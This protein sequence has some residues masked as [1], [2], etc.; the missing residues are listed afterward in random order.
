MS[1][2]PNNFNLRNT[3][4]GFAIAVAFLV[5]LVGDWF[6]ENQWTNPNWYVFELVVWSAG[7]GVFFFLF[8][9]DADPE[10]TREDSVSE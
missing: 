5:S 1:E 3:I 10:G 2:S 8:R 4:A 9:L 7:F 6:F